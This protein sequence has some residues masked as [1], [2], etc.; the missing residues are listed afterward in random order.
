M[1]EKAQAVLQ[2]IRQRQ[3]LRQWNRLANP[4]SR[5]K[6]LNEFNRD[7]MDDVGPLGGDKGEKFLKELNEMADLEG[8]QLTGKR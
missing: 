7:Q 8:D 1:T 6:I 2:K 4:Q 5:D 3:A